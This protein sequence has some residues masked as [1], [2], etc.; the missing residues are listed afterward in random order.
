MACLSVLACLGASYPDRSPLPKTPGLV[1]R[2]SVV[3]CL[4]AYAPETCGPLSKGDGVPDSARNAGVISAPSLD[5][6]CPGKCQGIAAGSVRVAI[7][8]IAL[9]SY[10]RYKFDHWERSCADQGGETCTLSIRKNRTARAV[11]VFRS[12]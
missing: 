5:I 9:Q 12:Y 2:L 6:K 7:K 1:T 8:A 4:G 10:G 11:A 3:I